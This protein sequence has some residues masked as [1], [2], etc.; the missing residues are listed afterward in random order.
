MK[1]KDLIKKLAELPQDKEVVIDSE[2]LVE[3]NDIYEYK[4]VYCFNPYIEGEE[5]IVVISHEY[6]EW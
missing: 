4:P 2:V 5:T 6:Q 3:P 1:V